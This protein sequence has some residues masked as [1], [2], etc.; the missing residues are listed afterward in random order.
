MGTIAL[1][2]GAT[3][4]GR[5]IGD[6]LQAAGHR[7]LVIDIKDADIVADLGT[8]EG[9]RSA[10][11]A[12]RSAAPEG[13]DALVTCA[14][15]GSHVP[16]GAL[17]ASVNYFGSVE[18]VEGLLPSLA[19]RGGGAVMIAS[20]SAPQCQSAALVSSF[21]DGAEG[22][23]RE[24]AATLRGHDVYSGSKLALARWMRR[25][26]PEAAAQGVRLNAV[27][28]GY[29]E[30]PMTAVVAEN[31]EYGEAIRAFKASIPIGRAGEPA[32]IANLV[33]FLLSTQAA[34]ICGAVIFADGGHDA[35][36]RP[37]AV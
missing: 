12:V 5:A 35:L 22:R 31:P 33:S 20:N 21:L 25:R 11:D 26:A 24:I 8:P 27:A 29:I 23:A 2:G 6:A 4:I 19:Q 9:R 16:D 37:D 14:G 28:P 32:D 34:F 36:Q 17:I 3:G 15:V 1:T 13:L 18:L 10:I 30:T 7:L